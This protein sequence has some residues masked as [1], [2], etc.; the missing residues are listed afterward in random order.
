VTATLRAALRHAGMTLARLLAATAAAVVVTTLPR[1]GPLPVAGSGSYAPPVA[2]WSGHGCR[3]VTDP[4]QHG[5]PLTGLVVSTRDYRVRWYEPY[6]GAGTDRALRAG[7]MA[8][9]VFCSGAR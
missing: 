6:G 8:I 5:L 1:A 4:R 7:R 2:L 9:W 3:W